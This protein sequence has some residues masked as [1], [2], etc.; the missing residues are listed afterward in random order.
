MGE[1][2]YGY[3]YKVTNTKTGKIYIGQKHKP[4]RN[5][6][7]ILTGLTILKKEGDV[8]VRAIN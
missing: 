5:C 1:Q 2:Y 8:D 6:F 3:I 7:K 4:Y